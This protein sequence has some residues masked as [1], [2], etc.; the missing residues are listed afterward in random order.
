MKFSGGAWAQRLG[1]KG[2]D[3][4][5]IAGRHPYYT[6]MVK[7]I[8]PATLGPVSWRQPRAKFFSPS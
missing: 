3:G 1:A 5:V 8:P 6:I 4:K 7:N 2:R